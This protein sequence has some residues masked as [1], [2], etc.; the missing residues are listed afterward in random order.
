MTNQEPKNWKITRGEPNTENFN[1]GWH[2]V[3]TIENSR[4]TSIEVWFGDV[5]ELKTPDQAYEVAMHIVEKLNS[6]GR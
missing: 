4:N 5:M 3:T 1:T 2:S 6:I